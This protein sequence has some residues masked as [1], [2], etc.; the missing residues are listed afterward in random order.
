MPYFVWK[1]T[2]SK[3]RRRKGKLEAADERQVENFLKRL[4]ITDYT[5]KEA[6][7]DI[8]LMK[9]KVTPKDL[10]VFTRQFSTMIDA[11]LPLVQS[12]KVLGDQ[13]ENPTFKE[14]LREVNGSV[15]SG[16]TLSDSL[17]KYPK[18]FARSKRFS[19]VRQHPF[20][21]PAQIPESFR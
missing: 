17:R 2:G 14:M 20:R 15:Q 16:S 13:Q 6:P 12:L 21:F 5:I 4:R 1:G 7:K 3:N 8:T 18:V 9:P 11:G 19:A 10:M